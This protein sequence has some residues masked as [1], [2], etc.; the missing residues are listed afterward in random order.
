[1]LV[2]LNIQE[3]GKNNE[4]ARF[5]LINKIKKTPL[6]KKINERGNSEQF[7]CLLQ[8]YRNDK[9]LEALIIKGTMTKGCE[10]YSKYI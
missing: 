2:F 4:E 5:Y 9:H 10:F 6:N 1:M 8:N 7:Y 3:E